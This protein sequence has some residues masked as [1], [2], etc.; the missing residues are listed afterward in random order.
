MVKF[1]ND[2]SLFVD[3][4]DTLIIYDPPEHLRSQA[5]I[6]DNGGF[7]QEVL[8]HKKHVEL[9]RRFKFLGY[10]VVVWSKTGAFWAE[11]IVKELGLEND[12][13]MVMSK[14]LYFVDD[15]KELDAIVGKHIYREIV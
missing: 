12:V 6:M 8:I 1:E 13:D 14:P 11:K 7:K 9:I 15:R 2:K 5:I 3:V 10:K 4:D